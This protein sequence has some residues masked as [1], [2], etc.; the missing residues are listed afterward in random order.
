MP[1]TN[2]TY[3]FKIQGRYPPLVLGSVKKKWTVTAKQKGYV[4]LGL[5]G[6]ERQFV[7]L[8][9]TRCGEPLLRRS[10]VIEGKGDIPCR[11]CIRKPYDI[12]AA[13][14]GA[15]I[16][17]KD[18]TGGRNDRILRLGCGHLEKLQGGQI[19]RVAGG[20]VDV[21]CLPCRF[22]RHNIESSAFGWT[23]LRMSPDRPSYALYRHECGVEQEIGI[24][25]MKLGQC[26]CGQCGDLE[27][28]GKP[29]IYVFKIDLPN[30]SVLKFGYSK[31]HV[32][33]LRRDLKIAKSVP[34]AI[35]RFLPLADRPLAISKERK[36]HRYLRKHYPDWVVP[37]RIF[38]D[39]I[40]VK[41][42]VYR[43]EGLP[44]MNRLLDEIARQHTAPL[45]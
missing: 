3:P 17:G 37:K 25:N 28:P 8:G 20:S 2:I 40:F 11:S 36:A 35:L 39:A 43:P 19:L 10:S 5:G 1:K 9:C 33:R 44:A 24:G 45:S 29:G 38:G 14:F 32:H 13:Q 30:L 6:E 21:D 22:E 42:E 18:P 4:V 41:S 7:V 34:T 31:R 27:K 26:S 16:I 12:A 23:F 15:T